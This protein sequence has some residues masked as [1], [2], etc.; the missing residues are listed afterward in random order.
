MSGFNVAV[1]IIV[2]MGIGRLMI[3]DTARKQ[4]QE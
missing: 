2:V 4:Q 1:V 3:A